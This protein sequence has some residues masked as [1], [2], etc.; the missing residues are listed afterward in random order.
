MSAGADGFNGQGLLPMG[1]GHGDML[2][3]SDF[4]LNRETRGGSLPFWNRGA[5]S[6]FYGREGD[7]SLDGRVRTTMGG[8]T[9]GILYGRMYTFAE[10]V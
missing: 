2:T 6:Q 4:A 10:R 1:L 7:L 5:Q 9:H 8:A 3:G